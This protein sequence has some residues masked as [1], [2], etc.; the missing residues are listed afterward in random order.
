MKVC[1]SGRGTK[2]YDFDGKQYPCQFFLPLSLGED[3]ATRALCIDLSK[4]EIPNDSMDSKCISCCLRNICS[5][6]YGANYA[7][8]GDIYKHD[9][10]MCRLM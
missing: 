9:V 3:A 5:T 2:A 6:C 7:A 10:S 8:T 1:G 4:D